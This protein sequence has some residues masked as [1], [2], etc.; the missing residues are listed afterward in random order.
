MYPVYGGP[1]VGAVAGM[2]GLCAGGD[3]KTLKGK[4]SEKK[5]KA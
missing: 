4:Q 2:Q 1:A 3:E 5:N